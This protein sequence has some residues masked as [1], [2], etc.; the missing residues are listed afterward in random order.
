MSEESTAHVPTAEPI[1]TIVT[2]VGPPTSAVAY[3]VAQAHSLLLKVTSDLTDEQLKRRP[4]QVPPEI[5]PSIAWH[6]WHIARWADLVQASIPGMT[7]ELGRRLGPGAQIWESEDLAARWGFNAEPA[8]QR[9]SCGPKGPIP[10]RSW[11][12][13]PVRFPLDRLFIRAVA[14]S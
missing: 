4:A 1:P 9:L 12:P 6:L 2:F 10:P 11:R 5:A 7:G 3:R 8:W 13:T 14:S